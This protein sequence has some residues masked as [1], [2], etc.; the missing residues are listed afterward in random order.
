MPRTTTGDDAAT[1]RG[2]I[3]GFFGNLKTAQKLLAGF[4]L[5]CVLVVAVGLF[6]LAQL[7]ALEQ[8]IEALYADVVVPVDDLGRIDAALEHS[9]FLLSELVIETDAAADAEIVEEI[10]ATDTD[11]DERFAAYTATDM[12]GREQARDGF[13][14]ALAA[15]RQIRDSQLIPLATGTDAGIAFGS[16]RPAV[17]NLMHR[18]I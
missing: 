12:T 6:G 16:D 17:T 4:L 8:R 18:N 14:A 15:W 10:T 11:L 5:M 9:N 7:S 13:A 1:G 3:L 2:G